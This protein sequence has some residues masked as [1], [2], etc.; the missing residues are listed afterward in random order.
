MVEV[1]LVGTEDTN[2]QYELLSRETSRNALA[3][4][5][6]REPFQN[7]LAL[8]TVSLGAAVALLNDLDW[9]LV[10][11]VEIALVRDPSVSEREWLSRELATAIRTDRIEPAESDRYLKIF[12]LERDPSD[13]EQTA[14]EHPQ[15]DERN[16]ID[17]TKIQAGHEKTEQPHL[18]EPMLVTRTG[19]TL[20]EYDLR[21]VDET[22]I[23]RLTEDEF[24]A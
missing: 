15:D 6:L 11:F 14:G 23:V 12:G 22:V 18:V 8:D 21:D 7:A 5:S 1:C 2:L 19:E 3:S 17:S 20:P 24:G 9:Y 16:D 10:R 4:Y 13:D